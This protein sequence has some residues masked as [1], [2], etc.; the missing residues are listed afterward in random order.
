VGVRS[1]IGTLWPVRDWV[2]GI[3]IRKYRRLLSEGMRADE[4]LHRAKRWWRDHG[5]VQAV[6][7]SLN[8]SGLTRE[9]IDTLLN[10]ASGTLGP[11]PAVD[12]TSG[13][14]AREELLRALLH[15]RTWSGY[16]FQG[17]WRAKDHEA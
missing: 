5:A 4:A 12:D 3:L 2:T 7:G 13:E 1:T 10:S 8:L 15:P 11:A 16:R 17:D 6:S 9:R 14:V